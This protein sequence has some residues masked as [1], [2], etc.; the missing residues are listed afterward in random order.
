MRPCSCYYPK[1]SL[2]GPGPPGAL[3]LYNYLGAAKSFFAAI[4]EASEKVTTVSVTGAAGF[5]GAALVDSLRS[6]GYEVLVGDVSDRLGR[7]RA[8]GHHPRALEHV[9][10]ADPVAIERLKMADVIVHLA[11]LAHVDYSVFRPRE[12]LA[13]NLATTINVMEAARQSGARVVLASSVEVYGGDRARPFEE[14]DPLAPKSPYGA[15]KV[16]GEALA[17]SY[18]HSFGVDVAVL[19]FTN[20]YGP[21]QAP[22][23]VIPR[24]LRQR[25]LGLPS[26]AT[27]GRVRDFL[28]V[29]DAIR[30]VVHGVEG[31]LTGGVFNVCTGVGVSIEELVRALRDQAEESV[32]VRHTDSAREVALVA[33]PARLMRATGWNPERGVMDDIRGLQ[34]WSVHH[35][36]WLRRFDSAVRAD[37][38]TVQALADA[39]FP[40][41]S[42][43][44]SW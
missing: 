30:A 24:V 14:D 32:C 33:S 34:S 43:S 8:K 23:R 20:L 40:L 5:V 16:A 10:F 9:D 12:V 11:A 15:S 19:R 28:H 3:G 21:W 38:G 1:S 39:A 27:R 2:S 41:T 35:S 44:V 4:E 7:W 22:D 26:T 37:T 36:D 25:D 29:D 31:A 18:R 42:G 6:G 13:T 17:R